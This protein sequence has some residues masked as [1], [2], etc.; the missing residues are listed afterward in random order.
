MSDTLLAPP[1]VADGAPATFVHNS[2][3]V[4]RGRCLTPMLGGTVA[5]RHD[6]VPEADGRA[7]WQSSGV[8]RGRILL[9]F[10]TLVE[11]AEGPPGFGFRVVGTAIASYELPGLTFS[12][13]TTLPFAEAG[14]VTWSA[15]AVPV[16]DLVYVY[17]AGG[18][19]SYVARAP[20]DRL[21]SGPW[22]FW[23]GSAW[24]TREALVP[25]TFTDGALGRPIFVGPSDDGF[26]AVGFPGVLP[27]PT[28]AGWTARRPQ[29]PWR[30][31]GTLATA[32]LSPGQF[33][34]DARATNLPGIG[35][36]VVYNVNDPVGVATD[37]SV[38]GGRFV[39]PPR[40]GQ[41]ATN[42][43]STG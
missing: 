14:G 32:T 6:L 7:C 26:V 19:S 42:W 29:G 33:P 23:T 4:Q 22:T 34:Y 18:G 17:G 20:F 11:P 1:A 25:M 28:I 31:R 27:D 38:Y 8:A 24:G 16:G 41:G 9:V 36:T 3:V 39:Q 5:Q 21:T 43:W 10:C 15:G 37:P 40:R 35:W 30:G 2:I 13:I 12:G